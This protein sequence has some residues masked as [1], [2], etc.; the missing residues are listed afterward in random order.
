MTIRMQKPKAKLQIN[1]VS[2]YYTCGKPSH[3]STNTQSKNSEFFSKYFLLN[4]NSSNNICHSHE[5]KNTECKNKKKA[6]FIKNKMGIFK[7]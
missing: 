2:T 7:K 6:H 3:K 1:N 5:H 4:C